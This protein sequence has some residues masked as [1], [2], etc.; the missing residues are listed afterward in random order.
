[1]KTTQWK[2]WLIGSVLA[3]LELGTTYGQAPKTVNIDD[4]TFTP[5]TVK[6]VKEVDT[7]LLS[8]SPEYVKEPGIVAAGTLHGKSRIYFYHVNEQTAPMKVGILLENKGNAPAFVEI[9]RAI[10]AKPNSDYF[11]VG[12]ELSKKEIATSQLNLGTW[13]QEGV[14][15]PVRSKVMKKDIKQE[16]GNLAQSK[17]IKAKRIE[18]EIEKDATSR[19]ISLVSHDTSGTEFVLR[20]G[21]VRPIFT[22]LE[23]VLMKQDD[24]F[25][26]IIDFSTTEPVYASVAVMEPKSTVTYGLP[27]LPIHPMDDVEL[28]GTY[29]GMRRF[30]IVE[31]QFNSDA[32]PA[33]FEIANDREDAFISGVDE[34]TNGKVVKNKGNYGVSNVYV[35]HTEG[36]TPYALY[37]NPLGGAFSGTFRLT[38]S[39]GTRTYDVPV[40]GPYLGHQTIYDTQLLDEFDKPEDLLLEY[41]SPGASNLPV[42]FLLIPQVS[43]KMKAGGNPSDYVTNLVKQILG[44]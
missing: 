23:K 39:K 9:K 14:N 8:D 33:S 30:H 32:G 10:Y 25:S 24:L 29:E 2:R 3:L 19:S 28:R 34:T 15:I 18:E 38:S 27:L 44:K 22:E 31:P 26:G 41:M 12:R 36:K 7:L 11:K 37:F 40:K 17:K 20:P 4:Y 5:L 35:L 43:Q 6:T 42:R 16:K 21:E 1:M 13:A